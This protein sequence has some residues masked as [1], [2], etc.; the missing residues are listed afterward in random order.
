MS[1]V[2][3]VNMSNYDKQGCLDEMFKIQAN[4][5]PNAVAV[6]NV[7]G[8]T[9][10]FKEL[11]EMTDVLAVKLRSIGV[12]KNSMVGIMMERCL[13]YTI[14][15]IAIHKAG[16]ACLILEVS[17]PLP[18]L[19][20]VL[21]DSSPKA[22]L[23]KEFFES[24]FKE[25]QLIYLDNGWYDSL[26]TQV[27]KSLLKKE[28]NELDD[29]ALVVFSS[30]TTGKP[31]GIQCPHRGAVYS[32]TWRHKAYP[33]V[34]DDR[35]ACNVFF[36]WEMIRP[37]LKGF[38]M[39]IIPDD[40]IYDPPRLL[41]FLRINKITRMLFTP[42]LLQAV[43]DYKGINIPKGFKSLKQIWI[44]GEVMTSSL[45]DRMEKIAPWVKMFNFYSVS[46]CHDV[47]C[48]DVSKAYNLEP[49]KFAPVGASLPGV[50][51]IIMD[52]EYKVKS[53]GIS[54]EIYV[55]G[56]TLAIGYLNRPELNALRFI[57]R[58]STVPKE[59][60]DRLYKTGDWG[61]LRSDGSLE[62]CGR[63]DTMVKI[64]GYTVELQA[65]EAT[66]LSEPE[67]NSVCVLSIGEEGTDK[68]LIGYVV[69]EAEAKLSASSLKQR[70]KL[71]LPF[72]MV[73]PFFFFL[74]R[75]P[76]VEASGKLDKSV[77]PKIILDKSN[78]I[79]IEN[80]KTQTEK[81]V[82]TIFCKALKTYSL[83]VEDNFFENGG[84][85]LLAA[86]VIGELN[87]T[88]GTQLRVYDLFLNPNVKA[89][90][91]LLDQNISASNEINLMKELNNLVDDSI[92]SDKMIRWF[93]R[94]ANLNKNKFTNGNVLLTGATG[95]VGAFILQ[96]LLQTQVNIFCLIRDSAEFKPLEKLE[97]TMKKY[98]INVGSLNSPFYSKVVILKGDV[99]L[100]Q[101][102]MSDDD[103]EAICYDID[104][105]IHAAAQVNL[106]YP[107]GALYKNNVIGT[108]NIIQFCMDGKIKPLHHI[109]SS[110]VFPQGLKD[111][112]E[113]D[114]PENWAPLLKS[115]Y[116]QTKW[117]AE[118]LTLNAIKKG[119][120]ASIFR[121]GNIS[122]S[123]LIPCWNFADFT[124]FIIQGVLYTNTYPDISWKI[125][126][127]PV[128]F[129]ANTIVELAQNLNESSGK[130]YH[131][132]N[133]T[134]DSKYLWEVMKDIGYSLEC[135]SY[136]KWSEIIEKNSN[137]QPQLA[138]LAYLLNSSVE[139]NNYLE[140]QSTVKKTNVK[141][142]LTSVNLEYPILDSNECRRIL[143][144]LANLNLIPQPALIEGSVKPLTTQF[145][146]LKSKV[147]LITG[148]SSGIG[149]E[150]TKSLALAGAIVIPTGRRIN[151]LMELKKKIF[152]LGVTNKNIVFPYE[153]DV[154]DPINVKTVVKNVEE[155][156]GP[157]DIMIINAGVMFYTTFDKCKVDEWNEMIQVNCNGMLNCLGAVLPTM[158]LRNSGH[159]VNI[160]S[161]A[162]RRSFPGLGVYSGTK[163]FMEGISS[164]LRTEM[165]EHNIKVTCIQPGD[166]KTELLHK[167]SDYEALKRYDC[168]SNNEILE[169]SN[170]AE[171]V[172]FAVTQ[173][174]FCA[175]NEILIEPKM[176]PI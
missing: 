40:A 4:A 119:L 159:I 138:S 84:H 52:N 156:I 106:S 7:D 59:F 92:I 124:L 65:I 37:L 77:L 169:P 88:F 26:K 66:I 3:A 44:C 22:I 163:F 158:T 107:F 54:G 38:P 160:T 85:S 126:L 99:S 72:Y 30:G 170:I 176:L 144:T 150:I 95:F 33:Y 118:Q 53:I 146:P 55:G 135:V 74:D 166:V 133:D 153:M 62:I 155:S 79:L 105:V 13:E 157:I 12:T 75:L 76:V 57:K 49:S 162:G 27:D 24:R 97:Q 128:D 103:Y 165:T 151:R 111:L 19:R 101:F 168:S 87:N 122:G 174:S 164:A 80:W 6:V 108:K 86:S 136:K 67:V 140:N 131:L 129:V 68:Y 96:K 46:E 47:T 43:L 154:T 90:A 98:N 114:N 81:T 121:C 113:D 104:Y 23:T 167:T 32:F 125:E 17:Y 60:G 25:Q 109:S 132:I 48:A 56:P 39:Y 51:I 93:W 61:Y 70:L 120:P 147:V 116:G 34:D 58:P 141:S 117:L 50:H 152:S 110:A 139:D 91:S 145:L 2:P 18:L 172:L 28:P 9:V 123:R 137:L 16:G 102:G 10:T 171:A 63:C 82:A 100:I 21:E 29:L 83:D 94:A 5:T 36:I 14:S 78:G 175:V 42:S 142:Y 69:L 127:T 31:K 41:M 71:K 149:Y 8:S 112:S 115:G 143:V 35:E 89:M 148:A 173:P 73:P 64:R 45:R 11:D 161:N 134:F 1:K 130:I 15:Y 20:S